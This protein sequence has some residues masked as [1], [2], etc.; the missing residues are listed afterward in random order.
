[1][2]A[3]I[4]INP[5]LTSNAPNTF[6]TDSVGLIQ[7][8]AYPDPSSRYRLRSGVLSNLETLPMWGGV[9]ICE[10]IPGAPGGPIAP[11]GPIVRRATGL[12][13]GLPLTAFSVFDQ[14]YGMINS[15]QSPVPLAGTGGQVMSYRL[16][17]LARIAV[18][19]D[20]NLAG[21]VQGSPLN[22]PV[23]WDFGNQML[24]PYASTTLTSGP[25]SYPT[26]STIS[27]GT[28]SSVTGAVSLTTNASHGLGVGYTFTLSG[29]TGTG[30]V[31]AL[32][33]TFVT[34]AGTTGTT[35]NFTAAIGLTLSITGGN[36]GNVGV[37][38]TTSASH[39]LL[40]GDTF[41]LSSLTGTGASQLDGEWTAQ[42]GTSGTTLNFSATSGYTITSITGGTVS[43]GG[44]LPVEVLDIQSSNCMTVNYNSSTGFA[45]WNYNS[46]VAVIQI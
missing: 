34:T 22:T 41:E 29:M 12:S 19:C 14:A 38:L 31:S 16:G 7:G 4:S 35:L 8:Q 20:P 21:D 6:Y 45:T 10:L 26:A 3:Q 32:N 46:C 25:F 30:S 28:Y 39:G 42:P 17:S 1:M 2:S 9:G 18:A 27:S 13:T 33:G 11:L 5:A 24:V 37:S 44:I 23:S 15:P 43:T 36:L 40:P